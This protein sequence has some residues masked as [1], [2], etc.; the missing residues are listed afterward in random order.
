MIGI[1]DVH[2]RASVGAVLDAAVVV[3]VA[4]GLAATDEQAS[5]G[6]ALDRFADRVLGALVDRSLARASRGAVAT[7]RAD[8]T[9]SG[10][11]IVVDIA[12]VADPFRM[13]VVTARH[14]DEGAE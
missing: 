10:G 9:L 13:A 8:V 3:A 7:A 2:A 6:A 11:T 12:V 14:P 1:A 4:R 5:L